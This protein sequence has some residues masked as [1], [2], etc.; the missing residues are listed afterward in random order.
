MAT[1]SSLEAVQARLAACGD[2]DRM[3]VFLVDVNGVARGKW[4]P[5]GKALA[6]AA[7][8]LPL[9]RSLYAQDIWGQDVPAAG[10]AVG[11]G[12]PD[13][14][15]YPV[16]HTIAP[17]T[18]ASAPT[19]QAMLSM[20]DSDGAPFFADPR[21]IL[22][23]QMAALAARGLRANVA[24]E[25]EFYLLADR[26]G[27]PTPV[28]MDQPGDGLSPRHAGNVLSIEALA[29]HEA[30]MND[31]MLACQAQ[32]LPDEAILHENS[33]GQFEVNL[34]YRP[35]ALEAA[36]QAILLKRAIKAIARRHGMR[37]CF[38]AKPFGDAAGSGMH[39]HVSLDDESGRPVFAS[40][41][42]GASP[43]L[44]HALGGV[45]ASM[46]DFMLLAAPHANSY[47]RFRV[48]NH[49][50]MTAAWGWG[51][52]TAAL[53]AI[54]GGPR[55]IRLEHRL[56]GADANPYLVVAGI[57]A[58]VVDGLERAVDPG[59]PQDPVAPGGGELPLDWR[60]AIKRFETSTFV[61]DAFGS[62]VRD[63]IAACKWQDFDGL[64]ARV[65]DAEYETYLGTV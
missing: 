17:V 24:I 16:A 49:A 50:P 46:P 27:I 40:E 31:L 43:E 32:G 47:R 42:G 4:L 22:G 10:L 9:P 12:D 1:Q 56:A 52:R 23:R 7:A 41:D 30:F 58:G 20:V 13:G 59:E 62:D 54:P 21:A 63:M 65:T 64:L 37:A 44:L 25:L 15:C 34:T 53:R 39:V 45:L 19:A 18:W 35:D 26:P 57:L 61:A 60:S 3:E 55:S 48:G 2:V 33:P 28:R 38:M 6:A 8:G 5:V 51:D 11:T 29:E 14:L 36:D